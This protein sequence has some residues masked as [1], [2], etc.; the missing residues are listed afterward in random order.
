MRTVCRHRGRALKRTMPSQLASAPREYRLRSRSRQNGQVDWLDQPAIRNIE[1]SCIVR[2]GSAVANCNSQGC[3]W[4]ARPWKRP[5]N[6]T[7]TMQHS[8]MRTITVFTALVAFVLGVILPNEIGTQC[9]PAVGTK[10]IVKARSKTVEPQ[11]KG[12]PV[13]C[14]ALHDDFADATIASASCESALW[15]SMRRAGNSQRILPLLI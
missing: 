2:N 3:A 13:A 8:G 5:A 15:R 1:W 12:S 14:L 4:R 11:P 10:A 9:L 7:Y 6:L